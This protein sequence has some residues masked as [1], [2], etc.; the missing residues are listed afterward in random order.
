MHAEA[1]MAA[2]NPAKFIIRRQHHIRL[3][4]DFDFESR[5]GTAPSLNPN[6]YKEFKESYSEYFDE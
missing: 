6:D 2:I 1:Y 5:E 3:V 4:H